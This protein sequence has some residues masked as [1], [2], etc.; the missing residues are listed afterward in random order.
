LVLFCP[1]YKDNLWLA[2]PM[3]AQ[4]NINGVG[5]IPRNEAH[6]LNNGPLLDF[7]VALVRKI[8]TEVNAFDNLYFEICNE[9]YIG[10]VTLDWQERI[11]R[12]IVETESDLPRKHL[13]AQN[14]AN[15]SKKIKNPNPAV[16]IFNFHYCSPPNAV[17]MNF[18]L[19]KA[20]AYDE[21]GFKGSHDSPCGPDG[22]DF[23][24]AGGA[25][26]SNLDYSF[27]TEHPDG[28]A[29][30]KAPGGGS[31]ALRKQLA[32]LKAFMDSLDF[33]KM[34]P[35]PAAV[36]EGVPT[37]ATARALVEPGKQY[38]VF[39]RGGKQAD[40]V[41]DLPAGTYRADWVNP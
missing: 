7:Q 22:W 12:V 33:V 34:A 9:P 21:T 40:L 38:A 10:G 16:S 17:A 27:T 4:N 15:G 20:I 5:D 36:K 30:P 35:D 13:I 11:A 26:Y 6:T 19:N 8:V 2:S 28:T 37:G 1:M 3:N 29:P 18:G 32:T 14:I 39:L 31:A 25:V 41:L 23:L 24:L